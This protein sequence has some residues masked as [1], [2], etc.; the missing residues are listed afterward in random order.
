[1]IRPNLKSTGAA[2]IAV[3]LMFA[4]LVEAPAPFAPFVGDAQAKVGRPLTPGSVAGVARRTTRRTIRRSTIYVARLP[5][6][7][8]KSPINGVVLWHCGSTYYQLYGARYVV[9]HVH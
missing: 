3:A 8:V 9:V 5:A 2:G 1:M 4:G 6:G 7:C